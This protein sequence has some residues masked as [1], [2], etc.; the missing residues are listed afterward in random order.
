MVLPGATWPSKVVRGTISYAAAICVGA[1]TEEEVVPLAE[2][3]IVVL[4][5]LWY[6]VGHRW[7][8]AKAKATKVA[9]PQSAD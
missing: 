8:H 3:G 2:A 6:A 1:L 7:P 9:A 4:Y 5:V